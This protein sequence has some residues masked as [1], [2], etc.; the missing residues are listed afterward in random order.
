[1]GCLAGRRQLSKPKR[2]NRNDKRFWDSPKPFFFDGKASNRPCFFG[3]LEKIE[4]CGSGVGFIGRRSSGS[5]RR[6]ASRRKFAS[7]TPTA[8]CVSSGL[9]LQLEFERL[10][11]TFSALNSVGK[12]VWFNTM[13]GKPDVGARSAVFCLLWIVAGLPGPMS[14]RSRQSRTD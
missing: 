13:D 5:A 14:L 2:S 9:S 10:S 6:N 1:M 3:F 7:L 4:T 8:R 12:V 11:P